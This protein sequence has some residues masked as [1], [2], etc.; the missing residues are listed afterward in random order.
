VVHAAQL[1]GKIYSILIG[2]PDWKITLEI[3][4]RRLRT[5]LKCILKK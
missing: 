3:S 2:K 4:R 5:I 1:R